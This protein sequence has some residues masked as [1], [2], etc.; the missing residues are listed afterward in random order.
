MKKYKEQYNSKYKEKGSSMYKKKHKDKGEVQREVQIELQ[1]EVQ[2]EVMKKY[3]E[4]YNS[5][6]KEKYKE[7][8]SMQYV[9]FV[10]KEVKSEVDK[11]EFEEVKNRIQIRTIHKK[12]QIKNLKFKIQD[13]EE[14]ELNNTLL[15]IF[16]ILIIRNFYEFT[17]HALLYRYYKLHLTGLHAQCGYMT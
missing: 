9:E 13:K 11:D 7:K 3:K 17:T 14:K 15:N 12:L 1:G 2:G 16:G 4:Q 8:G 5:K 10:C 6:Y